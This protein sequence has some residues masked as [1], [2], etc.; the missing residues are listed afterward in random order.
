MS[1]FEAVVS[2]TSQLLAELVK[3]Y[4]MDTGAALT[5]F[6]C[7]LLSMAKGIFWVA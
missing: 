5:L 7:R 3:A 6:L 2:E 1:T 4:G